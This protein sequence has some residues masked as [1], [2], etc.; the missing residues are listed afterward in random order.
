[1][2]NNLTNAMANLKSD[3][4]RTRHAAILFL[5]RYPETDDWEEVCDR[6]FELTEDND[7]RVSSAAGIA[8]SMI[9]ARNT[10][11]RRGTYIPDFLHDWEIEL[12]VE[13]RLQRQ[14]AER[15]LGFAVKEWPAPFRKFAR[16]LLRFVGL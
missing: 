14:E 8:A 3:D 16:I 11:P 6:V 7:P 5:A 9:N 4:P 10:W 2:N 15:A 12:E 13:D 1:M